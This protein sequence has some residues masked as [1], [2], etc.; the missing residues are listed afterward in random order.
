MMKLTKAAEY[1]LK[2][3]RNNRPRQ[4]LL[5]GDRLL[6]VFVYDKK[7]LTESRIQCLSQQGFALLWEY[8]HPDVINNI[9]LSANNTVL[10]SCMDGYV[11]NLDIATG[12]AI[13]NFQCRGN[14]GPLSNEVASRVVFSGVHGTRATWCLDTATGT[15]KWS[16]KNSGHSYRPSIDTDR[17]FNSAGNDLY[18]LHLHNGQVLWQA[19]EP[20]TY[21]F[22]PFAVQDFVIASGHGM[23]NFYSQKGGKHVSTL[24][25]GLNIQESTSEIHEV[26]AD[27][28]SIY[29][30]DR[31]GLFYCYALP[32]SQA[33]FLGWIPG[34][35][36][37]PVCKW[38]IETG[39][40]IESIP[41][42]FQNNV[43]VMN[44]SRQL[45]SFSRS[46]GKV[47]GE[48]KIKGAGFISG[49][50]VAKDSVFY[51]CYGGYVVKL[52]V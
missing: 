51:S 20:K 26:I 50:S 30:G 24:Y 28:T 25:T 31:K 44:N 46:S 8:T 33:G 11:L 32:E 15:K 39:G 48:I 42:F 49:L 5:Y 23:L 21:L 18:C 16:V 4:P 29:F 52:S 47:E 41:A 38:K 43:L 19:K 27:D 45:F 2:G 6:V 40:G 34:W 1:Q 22:N 35:G 17:V 3:E 10:A 36:S 37:K 12:S 9:V 14:I 13:W 7:G